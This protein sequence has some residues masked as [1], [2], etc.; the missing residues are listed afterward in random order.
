[1]NYHEFCDA[2]KRV[3]FRNDVPGAWLALDRD[4]SGTISLEELDPEASA[5]LMEFKAWAADQFGGVRSAF[6]V[7]DSDDSND[8]TYREFR[9]A[10]RDYGYQGDAKRLFA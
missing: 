4:L 8:L 1:M 7:L 5:A 6:K 9:R 3:S 2:C 10:V